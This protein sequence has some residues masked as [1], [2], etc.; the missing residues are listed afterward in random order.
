MQKL[1]SKSAF[2]KLAGVNPSTVTRLRETSLQ[3]AFVGNQID[4][5]HPVAVDYV[6]KQKTNEPVQPAKGVDPLYNEIVQFCNEAGKYTKDFIMEHFRIG[7]VRA[8]KIRKLMHMNREVPEKPK[9]APEPPKRKKQPP[10]P[11]AP[12]PP[13]PPSAEEMHQI[14]DIPE[15]MNDML[16]LSLREVIEKFGTD[17]RLVD[18][19]NAVQKIENINEKR[20][21]NAKIEGELVNRQLVAKIIDIF[22]S[23]NLKILKDGSKSIAA[24]VISKHSAGANQVECEAFASDIMS[25]FIK[26]AKE[27]AV[28][29]LRYA[30]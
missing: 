16:D 2:A 30:E 24:G 4:A 13:P 7:S 12:P 10:E 18:F 21:K 22:N 25:S 1:I 19:L 20:L 27:R 8:N 26:P 3:A 9:P 23:A 6:Q 29:A 14:I 17:A 5:A 11:P 28:V 15:N